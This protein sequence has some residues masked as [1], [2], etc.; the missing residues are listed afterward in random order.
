[1]FQSLHDLHNVQIQMP[2]CSLRG[3]A[4]FGEEE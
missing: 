2:R 4:T 1:M 3:I